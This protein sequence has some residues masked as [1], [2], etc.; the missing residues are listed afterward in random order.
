MANRI[1]NEELRGAFKG[2]CDAVAR[3]GYDTTD[4]RLHLG[5]AS[6]A[7]RATVGGD[8]TIGTGSYGYLGDTKRE[9]YLTLSKMADLLNDIA[10]KSRRARTAG[11]VD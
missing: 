7:Y 5:D 3:A 4:Y 11:E 2:Y 10:Y 1:T 6:N 9:A 8:G